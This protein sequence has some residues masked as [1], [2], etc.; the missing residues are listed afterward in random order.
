[1]SRTPYLFLLLFLFLIGFVGVNAQSETD[2]L[3]TRDSVVSTATDRGGRPGALGA[4]NE[5]YYVLSELNAGLEERPA[6]VHLQTPQAAL[7][8][9]L[10][11]SREG[12]Y[13][14]AAL[15]LNLN[16]L[17]RDI[18]RREAALLAEK[19][20][21]VLRQRIPI[22]WSSLPDRPD[23][24]TNSSTAQPAIEGKPRR[25]VDF[26]TLDVNGREVVL[27]L[28]RVRVGEAAPL[29]VISASTTENI[30]ALYAA[31]G[32]SK[33]NRMMPQ[34]M[35]QPV[36]G[37]RLWKFL[38]VFLFAGLCYLIARLLYVVVSRLVRRSDQEWAN[39]LGDK[40]TTP[41]SLAVGSLLFY[42]AM[43][44][45]LSIAGGWSP[46]LYS[47]LLVVVI[48]SITWLIMR[49]I[50]YAIERIT[51]TQVADISD[52][53]NLASRRL[54]TYL[55]VGRWVVTA[56][57]VAVGISVVL[58]QF[59]Q[60]RSLGVS[61][62]ASAGIATVILGIAAQSTL[63]NVIA[64]LQIA[65]TKPAR[66][67]DSIITSNG[68]YGTVEDI[69]FTYLVVKTW[70]ARRLVIPLKYFIDHPFEN[71]S[72]N[73]PHMLKPI[74]LHADF[75]TD[76]DDIRQKFAELCKNNE[77]YDGE[78]E[79]TVQVVGSDKEAIQ[80]RCLASAKDSASAWTLHV[81]LREAMVRYLAGLD[82]GDRLARERVEVI[83]E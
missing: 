73:D 71:W 55:S 18:Q 13:A 81:E 37:V 40:M 48:V 57:V 79:P 49:V 47:L 38:G 33:L 16:L 12:E 45:L 7:E 19:L 4:Y 36:L 34:W 46:Y 20:H 82:G 29:W 83:S 22:G 52:E 61:L 26:G 32:P 17:P 75:R 3:P 78:S 6:A 65:V 27:N 53:E 74:V 70:D 44:D 56:I 76:V 77:H 66:I 1:M 69:R 23:G 58:G 62:V 42:I 35:E 54:L 39:D 51:E 50:D 25:S 30:E 8:Y 15:V 63:G 41:I 80:I 5:A 28:Q 14:M 60:L 21:Y 24:Q 72:M 31:Y 2:R 10:R 67:G 11:R 68:E 64:G 59:P 9:F 43:N